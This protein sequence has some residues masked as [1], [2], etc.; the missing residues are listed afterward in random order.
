LNKIADAMAAQ[1]YFFH[2][3]SFSFKFTKKIVASF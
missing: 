1:G 2:K 3:S